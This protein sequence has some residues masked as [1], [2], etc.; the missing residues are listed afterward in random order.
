MW[1]QRRQHWLWESVFVIT[2]PSICAAPCAAV[3]VP[4][5][6]QRSDPQSAGYCQGQQQVGFGNLSCL[7]CSWRSSW[8]LMLSAVLLLVRDL[9]LFKVGRLLVLL[10]TLFYWWKNYSVCIF[11]CLLQR[12]ISFYSLNSTHMEHAKPMASFHHRKSTFC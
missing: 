5:S 9:F 10:N 12:I 2:Q 11:E 3:M 8:S 1:V 6:W 7:L 4:N